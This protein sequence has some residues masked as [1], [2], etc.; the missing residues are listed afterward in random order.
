MTIQIRVISSMATKLLLEDLSKQYQETSGVSVELES[1][2][3]VDATNRVLAGEPFDIAILGSGAIQK[4]IDADRIKSDSRVD[5]MRSRVAIAVP[6]GSPHPDISTEDSLR[7]AVLAAHSISFSTGP[8]GVALADLFEHWGIKEQLADRIQI[9]PPGTP[10]GSLLASKEVELG[11][12]Q[13]SEL[14][15]VEDIDVLGFMPEAVK[16]ES[17]FAGGICQASSQQPEAARLLDF[18]SSEQTVACKRE[19][20]MDAA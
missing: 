17:I 16:I 7:E 1:V 18:Y 4:L 19:H 6:G 12:Q 5:L 20:G 11:F 13:Y 10:V 15:Y 2:G 8:S 9:P 14:K 3:G